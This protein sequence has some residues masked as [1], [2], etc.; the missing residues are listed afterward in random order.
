MYIRGKYIGVIDKAISDGL[1][2]LYVLSQAMKL[3]HITLM[4]ISVI[5]HSQFVNDCEE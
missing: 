2:Y 5:R 1:M 3:A 4:L